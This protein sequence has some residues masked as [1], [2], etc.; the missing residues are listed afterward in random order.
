PEEW[1][2]F[3]LK[4]PNTLHTNATSNGQR[5]PE[6]NIQGLEPGR[7]HG[8]VVRYDAR[9]HTRTLCLDG[10]EFALDSALPGP[11]RVNEMRVGRGVLHFEPWQLH[12]RLME[13]RLSDVA[14]S[15]SWV[16]AEAACLAERNPFVAL[17]P[18]Q[19]HGEPAPVPQPFAL[20]SPNDGLVHRKRAALELRWYP[21]AGAEQYSI[22]LYDGPDDPEPFLVL[23]AAARTRFELDP[24]RVPKKAFHWTVVAQAASGGQAAE[25]RRSLAFYDWVAAG[26]ATPPAD[27]IAPALQPARDAQYD[28]KGYLRGR[29]D[30][31]IHRY[32][33]ETPESSPA[34]LQ[35]L[36]DRDKRPVR[37]PLVPWAGEFAGKYLTG[38]QLAWRLTRD[39]DLKTTVDQFARDLIACQAENGYLGPFPPESRLTGGNWDE[40]GHYHCMLGLMLYYE[41]TGYAPAL[42]AC[43]KAADLLFETF[44]PGGPTLTNDGSGGEM[45]MSVCHALVLLYKKT[46]VMRYLELAQYIV[47]EAWNEESA[48]HYL[49]NA[50]AGKPLIEF[51]RHRWESMHDWMALAELYWLTGDEQYRKA[52]EHIWR[53]A[54]DGD[55]HNTGG[56]TSGEGFTGSPYRTEAIETCCTVAWIAMSL[57]MLRLT[58]DPSVADEIEWSTLNSA[59]GAIPYSGRACAYN[60]PMDGTRV[61]GVELPWQSPKAGPD[62]NCCAVN[63]NRPLGMISQWALMQDSQGLVL[64]F[65]GPGAYSAALSSGNRVALT[66]ET[67]YP[68][69]GKV[70]ILVSPERPETFILKLRVPGWSKTTTL[71]INGEEQPAPAAGAYAVLQ[72]AWNT[73]DTIDVTLDFTPRFWQGQENFAGKASV[74]RGPLLFAFDARYS[75]L[76]PDQLPVLDPAALSFQEAIPNSEEAIT[77]WLRGTLI[78]ASGAAIPV[79]DFSSA[80][81]TG[82]HYRS[83]LPVKGALM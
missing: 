18:V 16:R 26:P 44:G 36:R 64:N 32:Y 43:T 80:G 69:D 58:G 38:A 34:M 33:I 78:D 75:D 63:A 74:Y 72:R 10:V 51:Q 42:E 59:L 52:F 65:Y 13:F 3:G 55:R 35:V 48:G 82:N 24:G 14:R 20:M 54:R 28:L 6:L 46:G 47:H 30:R 40:W 83:W 73:G 25:G 31:A 19:H 2:N 37:D 22:F 53:S 17:G 1:F 70:H 61:F 27:T 4:T 9:N 41:D 57:E 71:R 68:A 7:W 29:I 21:S 77:P 49:E 15:D 66:Q 67:A 5:A 23:D 39:A 81:Q 11:L 56:I 12:G 76:N 79:V 45:N 8:A 60:V 62:L 50:L